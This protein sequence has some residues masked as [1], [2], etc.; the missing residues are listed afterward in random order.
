MK[1]THWVHIRD[2]EEDWTVI[3]VDGEATYEGDDLNV[4]HFLAKISAKLGAIEVTNDF[5]WEH[6]YYGAIPDFL[7][8]DNKGCED[9]DDYTN[10]DEYEDPFFPEVIT[11][12]MIEPINYADD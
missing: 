7:K 6:Y 11:K 4:A 2:S 1:D 9:D 12:D 8:Y 5:I 10:E 3:Y